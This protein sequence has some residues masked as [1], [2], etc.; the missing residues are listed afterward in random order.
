MNAAARANYRCSVMLYFVQAAH[1]KGDRTDV[2]K[3]TKAQQ[4]LAVF[5]PIEGGLY[6]AMLWLDL[7][8]E[9]AAAL[10]LKYAAIAL[11]LIGS[12]LIGN[13]GGDLTVTAAMLLTLGA[14]TCFLLLDRIAVGMLF[15]CGVQLVYTWRLFRRDRNTWWIAVRMIGAALLALICCRKALPALAQYGGTVGTGL[16]LSLYISFFFF[17]LAQSAQ[18]EKKENQLFF[19]GLLLYALCDICVVLSQLTL[20]LPWSQLG[21]WAFYLPGQALLVA[22]GQDFLRPNPE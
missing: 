20:F 8:A 3:R 17:N 7:T 2:K 10:Y 18:G 1:A 15:F 5:L 6:L 4:I 16:V 21:M 22:S 14:D 11:C 19:R 12:F 9:G 13:A